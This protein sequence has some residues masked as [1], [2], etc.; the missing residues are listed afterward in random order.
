MA[1]NPELKT[2]LRQRIGVIIIAI[3]LLGSTIALY[4]GIVLNYNNAGNNDTSQIDPE[5][6]A[7][8]EELRA[9]YNA[10]IEAKAKELSATYFDTFATYRSRVKSFN[11]ANITEVTFEDL[12]VGTGE[13]ITEGFTDYSAYYIGW[14]S[15]ETVF[16]SSFDDF[17]NPTS[18]HFPLA[19]GNLIEG[20]NRGIIGMKIGGIRE[21]SIPAELAYGAN[22]QGDIP[23]NSPLKFIVMLIP[24]TDVEPSD[25]LYEL[26][27]ELYGGGY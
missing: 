3:V 1:Y 16:D 5:K 19:G 22:E 17:A 14:L 25:E 7:R 23:A 11:A 13:E 9:E 6:E 18:L 10:E 2:S 12:K 8:Y 24:F 26:Y 15:N 20:W 4:M 27:Y 21:I